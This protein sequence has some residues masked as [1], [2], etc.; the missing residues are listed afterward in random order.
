MTTNIFYIMS[1]HFFPLKHANKKGVNN[2]EIEFKQ[3]N[4]PGKLIAVCGI[5][6]VG[7]TTQI[8]LILQYLKNKEKQV[9]QTMQPTAATRE[10]P[11]FKRYIFHPEER[12]QIDYRALLCIMLS[13]RLQHIHEVIIPALE[14]GQIVVTDRYIFTMLATMWSRGYENEHWVYE[15][16]RHILR[17]DV[18]LLLNVPLE[19]AI[20]R[21]RERKNW[22]DAY[23][24]R[25]HLEKTRAAFLHFAETCDLNVIDTSNADPLL[26]FAHVQN[27]IDCLF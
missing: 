6:G 22:R 11:L 17:P 9:L 4:F 2:V 26:A 25:Q 20:D 24:E 13:D 16:C 14:K 1:E 12:D 5:D 8:E 3:H 15:A 23:V 21:I 18:T 7:K 10:H 27:L 19:L